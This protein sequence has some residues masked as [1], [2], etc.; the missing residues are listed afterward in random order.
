MTYF[1]FLARYVVA[2]T[3][4]LRLAELWDERQGRTLP[5]SLQGWPAWNIIAA[6]A[7]IAVAYT[8][9]WDNYLVATKVWWYDPQ[10]VTGLLIGYV[11]IEEY[12]FFILQTILTGAWLLLMARNQRSEPPPPAHPGR[13]RVIGTLITGAGWLASLWGL[14]SR[15]APLTYISLLFAWAL[16]PIMLQIIFGGD[17]L[18]QRRKLAL[19]ALIP[20]TL[21]LA[22]ADRLAITNGNWTINPAKTV[23]LHLFGT[24]PLEEFLFF[25]MTNTLVAFGVTLVMAQESKRRA[26]HLAGDLVN[27]VKGITSRRI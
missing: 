26:V 22:A 2:P 12:T 6:H 3:L 14:F 5:D 27:F 25:L 7:F 21:Y 16:P 1:G 18:W 4:L 15:R 13:I 24:L 11:P 19:S 23:G 17:V 20:T 9:L 8:T 10:R